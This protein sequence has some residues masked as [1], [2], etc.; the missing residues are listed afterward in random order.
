MG[1]CHPDGAELDGGARYS[2]TNLQLKAWNVWEEFWGDFVP[3][4]VGKSPY[5]L[6]NVG[7]SIDGV[8]H[9]ATTQWSH[10]LADQKNHAC[11]I[12]QGRIESCRKKGGKYYHIAGTEAHVGKSAVNENELAEKLGAIP[13]KTGRFAR[14]EMLKKFGNHTVHFSHHIGISS[15]SNS[16]TAALQAEISAALITA[17]KTGNRPPDMFVRGHRHEYQC[18]TDSTKWGEI[19]CFTLP[20]WQLKT[21][22]VYKISAGRVGNPQLGGAVIRINEFGRLD[23]EIFQHNLICCEAE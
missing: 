5:D 8:H 6:V 21:P 4:I 9:E 22:Y 15:A 11:F 3:K 14:W 13:D 12:L 20:A 18:A 10:N 23:Y 17:A 19:A 7:D 16:K 2:P 1:L